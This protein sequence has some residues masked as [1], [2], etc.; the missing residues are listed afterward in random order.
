MGDR[1][2]SAADVGSLATLPSKDELVAMLLGQ[3]NAPITGLVYVL[4]GPVAGLAR[5]LQR[6]VEK[7]E[8]EAPVN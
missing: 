5:V 8:Q 6:Q 1:S 2:L 4:N 3:M 7:L